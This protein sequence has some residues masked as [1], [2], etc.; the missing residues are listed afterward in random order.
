VTGG[1]PSLSMVRDRMMQTRGS[2]GSEMLFPPPRPRD[3]L[4]RWRDSSSA[5][6][7]KQISNW[8]KDLRE[9]F[10]METWGLRGITHVTWGNPV[11]YIQL[12]PGRNTEDAGNCKTEEIGTDIIL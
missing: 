11:G 2:L 3:S 1:R 9:H 12:C 8:M 6:T 7:L 10:Y 5:S 4:Y